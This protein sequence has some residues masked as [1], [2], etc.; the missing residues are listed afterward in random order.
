MSNWTTIDELRNI[1]IEK[2]TSSKLSNELEKACSEEY[3]LMRDYNGRQILELLQNVDDAYGDKKIRGNLDSSEGVEVKITFNDHIL[4][5]GNTGTSFTKETIERLCLGRASNKSTQNI[6]NKGT[7]F[8]SLL[9]DAEWIELYSGQ[10]AIR[11][12][13]GFAKSCFEQSAHIELIQ[14]QLQSWNK[15]YPL[16]F[17]IMN[18]PEQIEPIQSNFDTLIRVKLKN[19]NQSKENGITKQLN[20]PFYKSLLFLPNITKVIIEVDGENRIAEKLADG[21]DVLIKRTV[22]GTIE[23]TLDYFVFKKDVDIGNKKASLS[24]AVP[25][26]NEYDFKKETLY[27][28]FPI[29]EFTTPINALIHAP[30]ITN[31]SRDNVSNDSEGINKRIFEKIMPFIKEVAEQLAKPQY[32]DVAIKMVTPNLENKLW[33]GDLFDFYDDYLRLL[34]EARIL[35]TINGEYMSILDGPKILGSDYPSELRGE[36]FNLLLQLS[37]PESY[38]I[39]TLLAEFI[40]YAQLEFTPDELAGKINLLK[41]HWDLPTKVRLFLWWSQHY[42][43]A[44]MMPEL[45]VDTRG[46]YIK[47]LDKVFLP[48][49]GGV[50]VLSNELDWVKLCILRQDFVNELITQIKGNYSDEWRKMNDKYSAGK[51]G[52]KR[53]LD[54]FSEVYLAVEFTEQSSADLIIGTINRQIDHV[55]KAKS[56]VHWFFEKYHDKLKEGSELSKLPFNLPNVNGEIKSV[57]KLFL[58]EQYG[59]PLGEKLF[60]NTTYT[61]LIEPSKLYEGSNLEEFITFIE[62]CGVLKFPLIIDGSPLKYSKF[63]KFIS[64]KYSAEINFNINYLTVKKIEH[65]ESLIRELNTS[66]I[67]KWVNN[68]ENLLELLYSNR[69]ESNVKQQA[70]WNGLNFSSNEYTKYVLNTTPWIQL[71]GVRYAPQQ[72]VKYEKLKA[73]V[74]FLYGISEQDLLEIVGEDLIYILD[75]KES[76]AFLKDDEIKRIIDTLPTFDKGEISRKLYSDIIRHNKDKEPVYSLEGLRVLAKD[77]NFYSTTD[78]K[79]ADKKLPKALENRG[80]F[81]AIPVKQSIATIHKWLGVERFKFNLQLQSYKKLDYSLE[82]FKQEMDDIKVAVLS[83]IDSNKTNIEKIKRMQIVTCSEVVAI[84]R[85]RNDQQLQLENFYFVEANRDFYLKLPNSIQTIEKLRLSDGFSNAIVDIFKQL[86]TLE[87][88]ANLIELL[89]SKDSTR[90]REKVSEEFGVDRWN[91]SYEL[92]FGVDATSKLVEDYFSRNGASIDTLKKLSEVDFTY[93]VR[94]PEFEQV[95]AGL[96]EIDKDIEDVNQLSELIRIDLREYWQRKIK[97]Y[98][99]ENY[100]QFSNKLYSKL[101]IEGDIEKQNDYLKELVEYKGYYIHLDSISNSVNFDL[102]QVVYEAFPVLKEDFE[103]VDVQTVYKFNYDEINPENLLADEIATNQ[104]VQI[105]IYFNRVNNF[106]NWLKGQQKKIQNDEPDKSNE[107]YKKLQGVIPEKQETVFSGTKKGSST[108]RKASNGVYTKSAED[109][110]NKAKKIAGNKGELLIYNLLCHEYGKVN[111]FP[112][113]E[114]FVEIGIL[115]P[116][117]ASSGEYD[118]AYKDEHGKQFFVEVKTGDGQS[119]IITPGELQFAKKHPDKFKL[120]LVSELDCENPKYQELPLRFWEEVSKFRMKEIVERIE[121]KF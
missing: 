16:R 110:A 38:D 87:I 95:I 81:I 58:G 62:K 77:G 72:I 70:N 96:K 52:D 35:P 17:P 112:K 116:G 61:A 8:R 89:V 32:A 90:K 46:N 44:K 92:L 24:I 73:H 71:D 63:K 93:V 28:Y 91:D 83:T 56:F 119:F 13:E 118:L 47:K 18:C 5:V 115:K 22:D 102:V 67:V 78:V 48:T 82:N 11:F 121:V 104:K 113:S 6:G 36:Q 33:D 107:I 51:T 9:N 45:L 1:F 55:D 57:S 54:A 43:E 101:F 64:E 66:E 69:K 100:Q 84:D 20:Q 7:G 10:F 2:Y 14:E 12:S 109:K 79:Y 88:D 106:N 49:D 68:D 111:V 99:E 15:D 30:F 98:I 74:P 60:V 3:E 103:D 23:N 41:D 94:D 65:I 53:L 4:E 59:N 120:Y 34:S 117:Q 86:L 39:V 26:D 75:F 21:M 19:R 76:L 25:K 40:D 50:S 97:Q 108:I 37:K 85:E 80:H 29:R 27:C 31:T 42:G 114:A 105:M